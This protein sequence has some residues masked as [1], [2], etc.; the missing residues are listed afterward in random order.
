MGQ[1]IRDGLAQTLDYLVTA[2][3]IFLA[4]T[5]RSCA[6]STHSHQNFLHHLY[7]PHWTL[8]LKSRVDPDRMQQSDRQS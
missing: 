6:L 2:Q 4:C 1:V 7:T 5:T 8:V 3:R